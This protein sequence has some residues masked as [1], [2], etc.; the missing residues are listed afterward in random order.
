M[1]SNSLHAFCF[2]YSIEYSIYST[3][4]YSHVQ[5]FEHPLPLFN[6]HTS[7]ICPRSISTN[8]PL[9]THNHSVHFILTHSCIH[10]LR[11][12]VPR[13]CDSRVLCMH[14]RGESLI[15]SLF[16]YVVSISLWSNVIRSAQSPAGKHKQRHTACDRA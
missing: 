9:I 4:E 10:V 16:K 11:A 8:R 12:A 2:I 13:N 3:I 7:T 6:L 14:Y 5:Y 15:V 1:I